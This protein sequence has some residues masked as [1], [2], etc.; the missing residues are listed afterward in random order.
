MMRASPLSIAGRMIAEAIAPQPKVAQRVYVCKTSFGKSIRGPIYTVLV[1]AAGS[2]EGRYWE[3][4][5]G[6]LDLLRKG[7]SPEEL[8][9][10]EVEDE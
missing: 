5:E 1:F 9:L 8:E 2:K 4:R 3:C 6:Q 7:Y 10:L